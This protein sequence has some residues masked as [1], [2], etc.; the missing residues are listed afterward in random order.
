MS[1]IHEA[2]RKGDLP[3]VKCLLKSGIDIETPDD[4]EKTLLMAASQ[5]PDASLEMIRLLLDHGA[6]P[7]RRTASGY[8]AVI[9]A[10][11]AKRLDVIKLLLASG[12]SLDGVTK[13]CESALSVFSRTGEFADVACLMEWGAD[14]APLKWTP[15]HRAAAL[16]TPDDLVPPLD[17]GADLE[18]RDCWERTPL[19]VAIHAG[20]I[21]NASLL[22][23][24]GANRSATGRC[25][26]TAMHYPAD[27]DDVAML[28][29]LL[30]RGFPADEM[31]DFKETPLMHAVENNALACFEA[32]LDQGVEW[33]RTGH[34]G[35]KLIKKASHPEIIRRL[36]ELGQS[37]EGLEDDILRDWIG[38]GALDELLVTTA[39]FHAGRSR[40]F[41]TT[42][43]ERMDVPFW[44]AMVRNAW[45]AW[46]A[47]DQFGHDSY[48]LDDPVWC[49]DR[50]G[51]SLTALP[52]GRWVQIAGEHEDHYDP[53]FC[54]YNDVIVHDGQGGFEIFAYP[55][56]VFPPTDFHSATL[57]GEWIYI[58]GNLGYPETREAFG[59][60]TPVFRL[61][62]GDWHIERVETRGESPGWIHEHQA[63][64]EGDTI[65][66][67]QGKRYFITEDGKGKISGLT[68]SYELDLLSGSWRQR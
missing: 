56:E 42:N 17:D 48:G 67:F 20:K 47:A 59:Y 18:A 31:D 60:E 52:D 8:T 49:H 37:E 9:K 29:W 25:G 1:E 28:R 41:G 54:I 27:R 4:A 43:P 15:L 39:E 7:N 11:C 10:A 38:L 46:K 13:Y 3:K 35:E 62:T 68:G 6:D 45:C 50:F 66:V 21:G 23:E 55:E 12:A 51:M 19:L 33:R 36:I 63:K 22:L 2:V 61:H 14:P 40:R 30:D 57:L 26:R 65:R 58:I 53:D 16:G 32:L 5:S 44:N 64:P 24:C 34:V